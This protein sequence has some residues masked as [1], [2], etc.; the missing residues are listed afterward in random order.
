[1][2]RLIVIGARATGSSLAL[3]RGAL[4]RQAAVT[5]ITAPGHRLD[6]V[7]PAGV[8]TIN[9]EPDAGQL[10]GWLR[11]RYPDEIDTLRVTT[12]H[13]TYA[14]TAAWV[15]DAL[16]LPGPDARHVAHAVSKSNQKALL[17]AHGIPSA[18]FV[19]GTLA[20]PAAL[21]AAADPLRFPVVVKP[22][23]GSAS[24]GVRRC[25]SIAEVRAQIDALATGHAD[26]QALSTE[27]VVIEEFL[28]GSE[29]CVEFFDGRYVGALRKLKRH[30]A[31]FLER[32]Y[33]SELDLDAGTL[34]AL[35]DVGT[36][37][38]SAAGL[39]W[40]PVHLDCI[41]HDGVPHVIELNPRIAGSFICDIVRDGYGFNV[42]EALLD[43]LDGRPV[44]IPER[45]EPHAYAR[46]EFL[47]DSDPRAWRFAQAGEIH[48]GTVTI[49]YGPQVLPDRERR[50]FLYVRV[51]LPVA[52]GVD[53]APAHPGS[54][55]HGNPV[56]QP[57]VSG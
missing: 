50:A 23:E 34:R 32:G 1:M 41:V 38:T 51:A 57:T 20:A 21:A 52:H 27:R 55:A 31:G 54:S 7:F 47:L 42:V 9:L 10:A 4:A 3:V 26:A 22:S 24:D 11:T 19:T 18:Q 53:G 56:G 35:I 49:S 37:A 14:R 29:Y 43:K 25:E 5:V 39:T 6:G 12:A 13:D 17:A 48:D 36:R 8:E 2:K 40:G 44:E 45:F 33:T 15:A 16:G 30:G 28:S 46:A